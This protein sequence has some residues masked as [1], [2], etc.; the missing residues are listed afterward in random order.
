VVV[1]RLNRTEYQREVKN[2]LGLEIDAA[3]L[4]PKDTKADGFDNVATVLK[5][6]PSFLDAYIVAASEVS[7]RAIGSA[8]A[9]PSSTLYRLSNGATQGSHLEGMPLGTRGGLL[10]EHLFPADG[11]YVFN[12]NQSGGGGGGYVAGLDTRHKMILTIDGKKVFEQEVGGEEDLKF[13]DQKQAP[14][15]KA[16]RD[17][18]ANIKAKVPAGPHKVGVTFVAR[19]LA[20]NDEL[21]E[22][23]S[24]GDLPRVPVVFGLEVVGPTR[25]TGLADT[26]SRKKIRAA[27]R[28]RRKK[29]PAR[30]RS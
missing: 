2:L 18:F 16:I 7:A 5:V 13:V 4:L 10:V 30:S 3:T 25:A 23:F 17:R 26:P 28:M 12:V 6:S 21:L 1:H 22:T 29:H 11:E 24:V 8:N 27:R 19:S 15:A 14:A 20:Q 9:G